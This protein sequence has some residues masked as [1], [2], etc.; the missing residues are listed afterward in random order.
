MSTTDYIPP[1]RPLLF[2]PQMPPVE[3]PP[4]PQGWVLEIGPGKGELLLSLAQANPQTRFLAV[5][6]KKARFTRIAARIDRLELK[7]LF[8]VYG[9]ARECLPRVCPEN[10]FEKIYVLFPDP[11]PKKRHIKHRLLKPRLVN[12]L[13]S[14]LKEGGE[15]INATDAGFY[16][17][18]IVAAFD[19]VGGFY[20]EAIS[21]PYPT[22][23]EQKWR[24]LGRA[25][26]YWRFTK[27]AG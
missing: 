15:V 22:H 10:F 17:E 7:N 20:R 9:D 19:E 4:P 5:E 8:L 21:S 26:D 1:D 12:Q 2:H 3:G 16:S 25:I 6:Y 11:W 27:T 24:G 23:F 18:Q 14:L 13:R